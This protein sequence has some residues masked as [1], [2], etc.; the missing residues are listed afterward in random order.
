MFRDFILIF[1]QMSLD[2]ATSA[3]IINMCGGLARL[4]ENSLDEIKDNLEAINQNKTATHHIG[5]Y[6]VLELLGSGAFGS[7]YKVRKKT[8][9]QSFLAMK[10]V[11]IFYMIIC[12]GL[13]C[14]WFHI[15][16]YRAAHL[17]I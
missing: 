6:A 15:T 3:G 4:Q 9:G 16:G 7:V 17:I 12:C 11:S 14:F 2:I 5:D 10:E 8:A 1:S 13:Q